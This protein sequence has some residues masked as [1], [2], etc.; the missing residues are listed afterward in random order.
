[1]KLKLLWKRLPQPFRL[2]ILSVL[3]FFMARKRTVVPNGRIY[4]AGEFHKSSGIAESARLYA[5]QKK[6]EGFQVTLMNITATTWQNPVL[7]LERAGMVSHES[8]SDVFN[9][10]TIVIH[11]NPPQFQL[12]LCRLGRRVLSNK[13]IVAY[14][15]WELQELPAVWQHALQYAD[16]FEVPSHFV[17]EAIQRHTNKPVTVVPHAVRT[18]QHRK[19]SYM[20]DGVLH[21]LFIF[22]MASSFE[23]KNPLAALRAFQEA[24][25]PGQAELTFKISEP[26]ADP[27]ALAKLQLMASQV[28]GTTII[29]EHYSRTQ[30]DDLYLRHDVYLSLHRSEGYGLT[31]REA[32]LHGLHA[33]ATGWSGNMDFMQGPLAHPVPC[34]LVP[35]NMASGPFKGIK[36][37]WAEADASAAAD[38]LRRLRVQLSRNGATAC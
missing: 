21:C 16:A 36:G 11:A 23:R 13:R 10:G 18:P 5:E 24:F 2:G 14:W 33:V 8:L 29:T 30:L 1:M 12:A 7:S 9:P 25:I 32:M 3:C 17:R 6:R 34:T 28:P 4:V 20:E 31:I 22:N 19:S 15:A 26:D 35:V 37:V 38:I 27:D